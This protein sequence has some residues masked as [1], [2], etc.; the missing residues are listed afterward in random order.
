MQ[1]FTISMGYLHKWGYAGTQAPDKLSQSS[2]TPAL[3]TQLLHPLFYW[4]ALYSE[5]LGNRNSRVKNWLFVIIHHKFSKYGYQSTVEVSITDTELALPWVKSLEQISTENIHF[6]SSG[7]VRFHC[8]HQIWSCKEG[9]S[10]SLENH[11]GKHWEGKKAVFLQGHAPG[12]NPEQGL[13]SSVPQA[14]QAVLHFPQL[15]SPGQRLPWQQGRAEGRN[16]IIP[17]PSWLAMLSGT[18]PKPVP[19]LAVP[20]TLL[21]SCTSRETP[22]NNFSWS[23]PRRDHQGQEVLCY[24]LN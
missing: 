4:T 14:P 11:L 15:P 7:H 10:E 19:T 3:L 2:E 9:V 16:G 23:A 13:Q 21:Q 22:A 20:R 6:P 12:K 5:W 1:I 17:A 18:T 8:P 24:S